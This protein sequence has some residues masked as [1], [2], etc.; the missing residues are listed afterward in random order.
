MDP[1]SV[2]W[3]VT[4]VDSRDVG[5]QL[6]THP[7]LPLAR[8]RRIYPRSLIR[9]SVISDNARGFGT[10]RIRPTRMAF[11]S[12]ARFLFRLF[13]MGGLAA[14][15]QRGGVYVSGYSWSNEV[16]EAVCTY[17]LRGDGL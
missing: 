14:R 1:P 12:L 17:E 16:V 11:S 8:P 13:S 5:F 7:V 10:A 2:R 4:R 6:P 15:Q 3:C 9:R